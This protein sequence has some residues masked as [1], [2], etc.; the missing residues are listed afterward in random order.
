ME[1][2]R[3]VRQANRERLPFRTPCSVPLYARHKMAQVIS[4]SVI[5]SSSSVPSSLFSHLLLHPC[6]DLNETWYI[7]FTMSLDL[8]MGM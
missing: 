5:S 6:A 1:Y 4:T 2:L 8:H 3:W 7:Y